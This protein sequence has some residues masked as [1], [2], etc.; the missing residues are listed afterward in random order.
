[1]KR[2]VAILVCLILLGSLAL[3]AAAAGSA[4]MSISSSS[5]S[6]FKLEKYI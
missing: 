3:T 6:F 5:I 1:M 2:F 4:H